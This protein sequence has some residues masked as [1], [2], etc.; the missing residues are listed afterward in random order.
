MKPW[1]FHRSLR[2]RGVSLTKIAAELQT[3]PQHLSQVINGTR[4]GAYTRKHI[5]KYLT[6]EET[7][8]LGWEDDKGSFVPPETMFPVELTQAEVDAI[9]V[10]N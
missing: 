5:A 1:D 4:S 8:I 2:A 3:T 9:D 10:G 6:L 7:T